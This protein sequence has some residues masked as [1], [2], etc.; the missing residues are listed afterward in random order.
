MNTIW[1]SNHSFSD[2]MFFRKKIRAVD[3]PLRH[4]VQNIGADEDPGQ[5]IRRD[6]RQP[7]ELGQP[8]HQKAGKQHQRDR[9]DYTGDRA[10]PGDQRRQIRI[11]TSFHFW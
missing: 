6:V 9:D 3:D 10:G 7:R 8:R 2:F 4:E 1:L 11:L 5:N